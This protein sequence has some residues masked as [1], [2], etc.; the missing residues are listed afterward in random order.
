MNLSDIYARKGFQFRTIS[1]RGTVIVGYVVRKQ[2]RLLSKKV[3]YVLSCWIDDRIY[4]NAY[5]VLMAFSHAD[6]PHIRQI[7]KN[8]GGK[9]GSRGQ[10]FFYNRKDLHEA[11]DVVKEILKSSNT[12][13][14][15]V[16]RQ[17]ASLENSE[18]FIEAARIGD[19]MHE[20]R[21]RV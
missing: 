20:L 6:E 3:I 11:M 12:F 5:A 9:M 7:P 10:I 21:H 16:L 2:K 18:Q 19:A 14:D 13:R 4:M 15:A 1:H 17:H 8:F